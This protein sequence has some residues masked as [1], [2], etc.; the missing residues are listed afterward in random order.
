MAPPIS[1]SGQ[2]DRELSPP[3]SVR[4]SLSRSAVSERRAHVFAT[5]DRRSGCLSRSLNSVL[6]VIK[7]RPAPKPHRSHGPRGLGQHRLSV[8]AD[9]LACFG[10]CRVSESVAAA[11]ISC[12]S[13]RFTTGRHSQLI[14]AGLADGV[15]DQLLLGRAVV[16]VEGSTTEPSPPADCERRAVALAFQSPSETHPALLSVLLSP[17]S[18]GFRPERTARAGTSWLCCAAKRLVTSGRTR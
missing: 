7:I 14:G 1:V 3:F 9:L 17:A 8:F 15:S 5:P 6:E 16:A 11:R 18:V 13:L 10:R 12:G 4:E 2:D